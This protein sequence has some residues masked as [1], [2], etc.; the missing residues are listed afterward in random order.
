MVREEGSAKI[1]ESAIFIQPRVFGELNLQGMRKF[2]P[3]LG[4]GYSFTRF[5]SKNSTSGS[6]GIGN[7]GGVNINLGAAYYLSESWFAHLQYDHIQQN[8][9]S[10]F[11]DISFFNKISRVKIGLGYRF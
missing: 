11:S 3:F 7:F 4:V 2:K 8:R 1:N 5:K 6:K 10:V 9:N